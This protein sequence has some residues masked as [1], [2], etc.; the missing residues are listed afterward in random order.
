MI[1]TRGYDDLFHV[2]HSTCHACNTEPSNT[3]D[4]QG[5]YIRSKAPHGDGDCFC[6]GSRRGMIDGLLLRY[7]N[8]M[9]S[10]LYVCT[11]TRG[12]VPFLQREARLRWL[13]G[14][15]DITP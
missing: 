8:R 10:L 4:F 12:L 6:Y 11:A 5:F 2:K 9:G 7:R 15:A 3:G 14:L 1:E 13:V